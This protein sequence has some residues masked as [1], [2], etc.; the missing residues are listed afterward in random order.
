MAIIELK[1]YKDE[2]NYRTDTLM[3]KA[4]YDIKKTELKNYMCQAGGFSGY[5]ITPSGQRFYNSLID[6]ALEE[7][8]IGSDQYYVIRPDVER[9]ESS[10]KA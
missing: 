4:I 8:K 9:A 10:V 7:V 5:K 2:L 6:M 3:S 1:S